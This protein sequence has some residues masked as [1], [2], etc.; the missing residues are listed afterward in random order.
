MT[1]TVLRAAPCFRA[2]GE[3]KGVSAEENKRQLAALRALLA[4][5]DDRRCADCQVGAMRTR[6]WHMT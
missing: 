5:P 3:M 6:M 4:R 1:M 2:A